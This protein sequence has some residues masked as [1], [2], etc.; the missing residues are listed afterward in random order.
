MPYHCPPKHKNE[1][2][3]DHDSDTEV[4]DEPE[5]PL[6]PPPAPEQAPPCCSECQRKIPTH[7]GNIY[8]EQRHPTKITK[9]V[10]QSS[11][12]KTMV[13]DQPSSSR[14]DHTP[15]QWQIPGEFPKTS[16]SNPP[17]TSDAP[18]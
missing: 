7:P 5:A 13:E 15:I 17:A 10:E 1:S 9:D 8:G 2:A 11:K 12:W 16:P 14:T 18:P 6:P 3:S 4:L